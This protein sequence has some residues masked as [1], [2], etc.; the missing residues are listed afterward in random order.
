MI[1]TSLFAAALLLAAPATAH[2]MRVNAPFAVDRESG[3]VP[4]VT[5]IGRGHAPMPTPAFAPH[6][7][8]AP[9]TGRDSVTVTAFDATGEVEGRDAPCTGRVEVALPRPV[10]V[11]EAAGSHEG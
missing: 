1:R 8:G 3:R 11:A 2:D 9:L 10:P 7:N 5:S 4:V 6:G